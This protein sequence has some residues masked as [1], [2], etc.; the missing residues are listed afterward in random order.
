M[1]KLSKP[2]ITEDCINNVIKVLRSGNLVQGDNVKDLEE[3]FKAYLGIK[4][5]V[6]VSS[7]T[8]ALHLALQVLGISSGDEVIVPAFTFPATANVVELLGAKAVLVD[9]NLDDFCIN[10]SL[11][12][13]A[14]TSRTKAIMPVHEFGQAAQIDKVMEIAEKYNLRVVEDAACALG[15]EFYNQKTGTFGDIGC[16]SLHPRKAVTSGEGGIIITNNADIANSLI[17]L[18]NH[19]IEN[20]EGKIDFI[21]AGYNYRMTDFQAALCLP[22][23]DLIENIIKER[24]KQANIYDDYLNDVSNIILPCIFPERK[25]VY[26]TYHLL[27]DERFDRN[28]VIKQLKEKQIETNYGAYALN[29]LSYYTKKYGYKLNDYPN[30]VFAN[31][32]GLALPMGMHL[33]QCDLEEVCVKLKA[34]LV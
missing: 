19:G 11:I 26:Q 13:E 3:R 28:T 7:G 16:F 23:L 29:T 27:L 33:Q 2:Y 9:I 5:A 4:Y 21:N 15:T 24:I 30:A 25:M 10:T 34:L 12:E 8:A 22:Q 20:T 31:K 32:H 17:I 14:I 18:R 1:I 6:A